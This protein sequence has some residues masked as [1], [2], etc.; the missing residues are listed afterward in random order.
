MNPEIFSKSLKDVK[1]LAQLLLFEFNA[2]KNSVTRNPFKY[3][4][5]FVSVNNNNNN[6]ILLGAIKYLQAKL[7]TL[8]RSQKI[9]YKNLRH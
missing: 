2:F 1:G 6:N 9:G 7:D 8:I 3:V 5:A 4:A